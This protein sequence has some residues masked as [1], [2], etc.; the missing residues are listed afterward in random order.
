VAAERA[1]NGR[2]LVE[3][4]KESPSVRAPV[5]DADLARLRRER[6]WELDHGPAHKVLHAVAKFPASGPRNPEAARELASKIYNEVREATTPAEFRQRTL[7][8][9]NND[10]S[11]KV[12]E[13]EPVLQD[14]RVLGPEGATYDTAFAQAAHRVT[15]PGDIGAPSESSFGFHVIFLL[16]IIPPRQF[17]DARLRELVAPEVHTSRARSDLEQLL[18]GLRRASPPS[19]E[20]EV[21]DLLA[22]PVFRPA[23]TATP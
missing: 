14:G 17:D 1:A 8:V 12:E 9:V 20:R 13:L 19:V 10:P 15:R 22:R 3:A 6:W 2:L 7:A 11:V 23:S 21:D 4:I 18:I 16:E 5:T